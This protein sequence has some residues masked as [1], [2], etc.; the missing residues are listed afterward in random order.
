M[1]TKDASAKKGK[2]G[3]EKSYYVHYFGWNK[4]WDEWIGADRLHKRDSIQSNKRT[5]RIVRVAQN[6][7]PATDFCSNPSTDVRW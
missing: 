7:F 1:K 6:T 3:K 4:K 2:G 5:A